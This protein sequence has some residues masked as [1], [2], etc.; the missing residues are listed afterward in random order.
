M[1]KLVRE[2]KYEGGFCVE[3]GE[4][5]RVNEQEMDFM[6]EYQVEKVEGVSV[7]AGGN[8]GE[9]EMLKWMR[10]VSMW[11]RMLEREAAKQM[12]VVDRG[13]EVQEEISRRPRKRLPSS[14]PKKRLP[15]S[16]PKRLLCRISPQK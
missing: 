7:E 1:T 10:I 16:S 4:V 14:S 3:E 11:L 2:A 5:V 9:R 8:P 6:W 13:V 15:R 12:L